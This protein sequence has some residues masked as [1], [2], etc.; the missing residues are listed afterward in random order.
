[1]TSPASCFRRYPS[2]DRGAHIGMN[3]FYGCRCGLSIT[4]LLLCLISVSFGGAR[5]AERGDAAMVDSS[6]KPLLDVIKVRADGYPAQALVRPV[7]GPEETHTCGV[8]IIGGGMGGVSAALTAANSGLSVCLTEATL[9]LGGQMTSEGVSAFDEN[10]WIETTGATATYAELRHRII[11]FYQTRYGKPSAR[12][13]SSV[14]GSRFNPGNCWVSSLCFQPDSG[15]AA[16][17]SMLQPAIT[18]G[19]LHIWLHTVPTGVQRDGRSILIAPARNSHTH[20][21]YLTS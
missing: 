17:Q 14:S 5:R 6:S 16:L 2:H 13:A 8:V 12:L 18:S 10:K 11:K 19:K 15:L 1:M 3:P 7:P 20:A 21:A 9:W 4:I